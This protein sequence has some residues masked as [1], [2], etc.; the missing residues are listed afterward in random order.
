VITKIN[1]LLIA[2]LLG[3]LAAAS[4]ADPPRPFENEIIY[5]FMP[6]SWRD[7]NNDAQRFGDFDGMTASL[8]YLQSLGVTMVWMNPIFPSPAYHGYQHGPADQLNPWF[9]TEPQF[10]NFVNQAHARGIKVFIDFVVYGIS[11]NSIWFQSAYNNPAS[12]YDAWLA[13][14]NAANTTYDGS[15]Y[16]TWNGSTVGFISWDLNNANPVALDTNWAKHWLDPN[17]D[18]DPSDGIDGYRLDHVLYQNTS[19]PNGWGYNIDDFWVPWKTALQTVNPNVLTFAE[20]ADWGIT[21]ANLMAAFDATMTKPWEFAVRDSLSAETTT[22]IYSQTAA[23]LAQLPAGKTFL[24]EIGD[25]DVDRVT[26]TLGGSLTKAK[27]AAAILLTSPF[28]PM[29]YNGD[30]IG[31]LG[32]KGNWGTDA[33]DIP[34]REPFKWNAVAGPPMSNYFVLN[35]SAYNARFSQNNDGR[36]VQEQNG[37]SG[38]LLEAYK[39]LITLRKTHPAL[40]HGQY[41][42]ITNSSTRHWGFLRYA[43]GEETLFVV[44]RVRSSSGTSTFDL[45]NTTIP[46][47]STT[48]VDLV[49]GQSLAA[50]TDAN[51]SAY[52][53]TLPT[54]GYKILQVNL[55][56]VAPPPNEIDGVD[57]PASLGSYNVRATQN[58]ATS[59]GDNLSELDQLFV[60][61]TTTGLRI[62]ITGNLTTDG[63]GLCL[64]LDTRSG[65]QNV[66]NFSGYTPPPGGPNNLTGTRLDAG[67]EP[68]EM[69]F[70]NTAGG[71]I[72]VDQFTL[73]PGGITK[74][75]KGNGTINDG[76][77]LLTGGSNANAMQVAMNN[78]NTLGVTGSSATNAATAR[79][80]FDL[81]IPYA[82]VGIAGLTGADVKIA[83]F[84]LKTTGEVTNQW[85]P[86]LGG[87]YG[88]LGL[89]PDL[90]T[91]PQNQ[92]VAV[93][94]VVPGDIDADGDVDLADADALVNVLLDQPSNPAHPGRSDLNH[95]GAVNALD[96]AAMT[97]SLMLH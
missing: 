62:G 64:F 44:I 61:P 72:Y 75:Y 23:T 59:L 1:V 10:L 48:P 30:E 94:L 24:G 74:L 52:T 33:N 20:Q 58:N 40:R 28:P 36:S 87:G 96:I 73:L 41:V 82:D 89:A 65:G 26:S 31:M 22:S 63:T 42:P 9:G 55:A 70:I 81:F 18:G 71:T 91:V 97:E 32:T 90:T 34:M 46:G 56:P 25:H 2:L 93:P 45:T 7:S 27:A 3:S 86:G 4:F 77:G 37:V 67:F 60:R 6:I 21:G 79:N 69:I 76:D 78:N 83:A 66:L 68:D 15:V 47:G 5:Q 57:V 43:E 85:L 95:D 38:S 35:A 51:K 11:Q 8:D 13:F 14:T 49:T 29:I 80:G 19:G 17:N 88:N 53:I 50:I 92:F 39:Q 16:T 84:I 54:Y 12:P